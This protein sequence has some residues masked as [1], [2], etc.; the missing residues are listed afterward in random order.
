MIMSSRSDKQHYENFSQ[1]EGGE[2]KKQR[3]GGKEEIKKS[4]NGL[5][6]DIQSCWAAHLMT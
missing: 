5:P 1:K 6:R 4:K 3:E 2:D